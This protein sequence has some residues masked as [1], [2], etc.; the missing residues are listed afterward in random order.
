MSIGVVDKVIVLQMKERRKEHVKQK[1][2]YVHGFTMCFLFY[3]L[4]RP[5][6]TGVDLF[7][8]SNM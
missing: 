8:Q 2:E 6:T 1:I 7:A 5:S 4:K 3:P